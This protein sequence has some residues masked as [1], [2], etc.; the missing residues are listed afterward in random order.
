M[1]WKFNAIYDL[2]AQI[3][4]P[5]KV[6]NMNGNVNET[7]ILVQHESCKCKWKKMHKNKTKKVIHKKDHCL[8]HSISIIVCLFLLVVILMTYFCCYTSQWFKK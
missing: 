8:F 5:N 3:W 6:K 2:Y 4:I 7:I 1:Q